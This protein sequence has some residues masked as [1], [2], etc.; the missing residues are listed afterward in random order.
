MWS[1]SREWNMQIVKET[2]EMVRAFFPNIPI[3]PVI[4]NHEANPLDQFPNPEDC[5][6]ELTNGWLYE[7]ITAQWSRVV[8]GL[9]NGTVLYGGYYSVLLKP[10]FRII[11]LNSMFG[12][13][14]NV[15][16]TENSTDLASELFWLEAELGKAEAAGEHVHLLGHIPPGIVSAERTW[17]REYNRII[18]RY[19]NII[20][21]QFFGHTHSDEYEVFLED[22]RAIGVAYIAP[23]QTPWHNYNPSY[24]IY[25]VDGDRPYT[26]RLVLDHT[27]FIMNL[28]EA[29]ETN[30]SRWYGLYNTKRD[31]EMASLTPSDWLDLSYRMAENRTLF[32]LYWRNYL[33]A[34]DPALAE[35]C[36]DI[37]YEQRLC[38]TVTSDRNDLDACYEVIR[39]KRK[40]IEDIIYKKKN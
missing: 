16:L 2:N 10:G 34:A 5:P 35:E 19:E 29:H 31:Y 8:P 18:W 30:V 40:G 24:R 28:T 13:S 7:E 6:A 32:D 21:A 26:T 39:R 11:S 33:S 20:R 37:C 36:D 15:W 9:E 4:G 27:T 3:F 14:S 25:I 22:D 23:S 1:T 38:D 12:Y 17:S